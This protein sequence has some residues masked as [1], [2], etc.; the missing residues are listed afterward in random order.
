MYDAEVLR[1]NRESSKL[2]E[3]ST[4]GTII[5]VAG[6]IIVASIIKASIST[7]GF[8]F[9]TTTVVFVRSL[10]TIEDS[11]LRP[12]GFGAIIDK[13]VADVVYVCK[14]AC[15]HDRYYFINGGI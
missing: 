15:F 7:A 4:V 12:S 3:W 10:F 9:S 2:S 1:C 11:V 14:L 8:T 13:F 6:A 5:V